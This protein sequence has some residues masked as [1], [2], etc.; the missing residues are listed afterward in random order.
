MNANDEI[1]RHYVAADAGDGL[2]E[3]VAAIVDG[4]DP[5]AFEAAS[6]A[7]FDQFH[8]RGIAA[9]AELAKLA[10]IDAT[11]YV[12]DAGSGFG[13][14]ARYL[15]KTFGCR[16]A[17]IDLTPGFV[18]VARMFADRQGL[19]ALVSYDVG[20]LAA[21][22]YADATFD[23]VWT[24]HAVMNVP[25]RTRVYAE[26]A[27]VLEP[28][29]RIAFYDV[30]AADDASQPYYPVPWAETAATSF[31]LTKAQTVAAL[32]GAGISLV[33]WED[34]TQTVLAWFAQQTAPVPQSLSLAALMG[35]RFGPMSAN[36]A[37]SV[38]E[39]K[40]RVAMG[41]GAR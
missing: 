27:R 6:D 39:G 12:L 40:V 37:K 35:P 26:F 29:G 41:L 23:V 7:G 10:G 5:K 16:V 3:K 17:G 9:T 34:V 31:L 21:L 25:N 20:D 4:L 30:V 28:G 19:A 33:T 38:R 24:Q 11:S 22:P 1:R 15:A 18:D 36:F 13:G 2:A 14:P 32:E 8:V